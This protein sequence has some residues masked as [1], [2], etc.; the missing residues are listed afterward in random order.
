MKYMSKILNYRIIL[1]PA[2]PAVTIAGGQMIAPAQAGVYVKFEDGL[3]SVEDEKIIEMLKKHPDF[4]TEFWTIDDEKSAREHLI[5][6]SGSGM[7]PEHDQ[8]NI[9]YGHVGAQ[10]NP[11]VGPKLTP[12]MQ[13][14]LTETAAKMAQDMLHKMMDEGQLVYKDNKPKEVIQ[15]TKLVEES[16]A[17][18]TKAPAP[19]EDDTAIPSDPE[20]APE[21]GVPL[22]PRAKKK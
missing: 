14:F 17:D 11:K 5:R 7:E 2:L 10:K 18:L 3:L 6:P 1:Q 12:E 20:P 13:K 4:N 15:P 16:P 8:I 9:E 22:K 19:V 21:P